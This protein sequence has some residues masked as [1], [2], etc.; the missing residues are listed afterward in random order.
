MKKNL[1]KNDIVFGTIYFLVATLY[2]ISA[3]TI[4]RPSAEINL[5]ASLGFIAV[6]T[7][8]RYARNKGVFKAKK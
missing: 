3:E 2:F 4:W 6:A 7:V 1:S 5:F 8:Y